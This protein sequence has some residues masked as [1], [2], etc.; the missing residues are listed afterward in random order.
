MTC[1]GKAR[2]LMSLASKLIAT[3]RPIFSPFTLSLF[4]VSV[5]I[6]M[7]KGSSGSKTNL[8]HNNGVPFCFLMAGYRVLSIVPWPS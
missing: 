7:N 2:L 8:Y 1:P 4:L 5:V 3:Y 6:V